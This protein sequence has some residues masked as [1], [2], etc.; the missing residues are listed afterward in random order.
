MA[1]VAEKT[2]F[3][4]YKITNKCFLGGGGET[5][6]DLSISAARHTLYTLTN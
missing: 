3:C 5:R 6:A 2:F 4:P 1:K